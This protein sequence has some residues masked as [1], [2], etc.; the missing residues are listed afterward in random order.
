MAT[1]NVALCA[2]WMTTAEER[3]A[4]CS[5]RGACPMHQGDEEGAAQAVT[6]AEADSCCAASESSDSAPTAPTLNFS[7]S[8]APVQSAVQLVA[9]LPLVRFDARRKLASIPSASVP[10]HVILSVFLV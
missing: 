4:C 3:M 5:E 7:V 10:K 1:S 8:L 9:S 2:G 6:Q